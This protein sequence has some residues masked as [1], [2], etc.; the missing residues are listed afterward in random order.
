MTRIRGL[1]RRR[2]RGRRF[3]PT[4]LRKLVRDQR[5][6]CALGV[7]VQPEGALHFDLDGEDLLVEV[8]LQPSQ[9]DVTCR[10]GSAF[11]GPNLGL[12]QVPPVGA[13][14]AV[15]LPEGELDFQPTVVAVLSSGALPDGV[16]QNTVVIAEAKVLVHDGTGGAQPLA[17]K[18]DVDA[19]A[20]HIDQ[21]QHQEVTQGGPVLTSVPTKGP[22]G[23]TP[24]LDA[25][26]TAAGTT[27]LETK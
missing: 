15:L 12:W 11:G 6:W 13:E 27:V 14:V 16:A 17:T 9:V 10:V 7:V 5:L 3:D 1:K 24:P 26:P 18:A 25:S 20:A 4:D 19:L 22:T 8:E 21:H 2:M 23:P